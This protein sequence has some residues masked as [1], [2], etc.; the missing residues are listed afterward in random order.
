MLFSRKSENR[1]E[2]AAAPAPAPE[3][4]P[5]SCKSNVGS[6]DRPRSQS[7]IDASLTIVGDL[8]SEGDVRLDGRI[9]GNVTCAQL[10]VSE[11]A[12]I[13]GAVTAEETIVRGSITGKIRSPLV[14]LQET[15]QVESEITYTVLAIDDGATFEGAA[16]RSERPLEEPDA[17]SPLLELQQMLT[18]ERPNSASTEGAGAAGE[19]GPNG[20]AASSETSVGPSSSRLSGARSAT[21]QAEPEVKPSAFPG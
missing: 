14:I 12:S 13:T 6:A 20:G 21:G 9:C 2:Q 16:R 4:P 17:V 7:F 11:D 5:A 10:I 18:A 8:H 1:S 3:A 15:A 19:V